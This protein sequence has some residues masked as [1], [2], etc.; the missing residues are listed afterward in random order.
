MFLNQVSKIY[1]NIFI[2][3]CSLMAIFCFSEIVNSASKININTADT[4]MLDSLP[5]IGVA[6]AEDIIDYR[7]SNGSF[8]RIEDL[9][10]VTGIGQVTFDGLKD[11]ICVVDSEC[12][13][14]D[15]EDDNSDDIPPPTTYSDKIL[16]NE[17][18]PNPAGSDT[19][20]WV[21][22]FNNSDLDVDLSG[23]KISDADDHIFIIPDGTKILANNFFVVKN[24]SGVSLNN[25]GDLIKILQPDDNI[26]HS[27]TYGAGAED[28]YCWA[29][30][31]SGDFEW[32]TTCT[33][34]EINIITA[35][36]PPDTGGGGGGGSSSSSGDNSGYV[37][38]LVDKNAN[39]NTASG[40]KD[41][42][43]ITEIFPNPIGIDNNEWIEI[44]NT[45]TD[46]FY[47]DNWKLKDNQSEYIIKNTNLKAKNF[48]VFL[49]SDTKFVLN[50]GGDFVE[51]IDLDNK[52]VARA[53]YKTTAPENQSYNLCYKKWVWLDA[54][55]SAENLCPLPNKLPTAF[56]E[57]TTEEFSVGA[58]IVL[59]AYE[60]FDEDGQ[61][62]KYTWQFS[63]DI[64]EIDN[65]K[66]D[67]IFEIQNPFFKFKFLS[68]GK[69]KIT[70]IITDDLGGEDKFSFDINV[71]G[72]EVKKI[73]D[74]AN[75]TNKSNKASPTN[76]NYFI[77]TDLGNLREMEK[78]SKVLIQ[79]FVSAPPGILGE[80]IFYI[81]GS[82]VQIYFSKKDFPELALGDKIQISGTISSYYNET[83]VKIANK[84]DI[85][86][87]SQNNEEP[88]PHKILLDEIGEEYEG[89]LIEIS[90]D[91]TEIKPPYFWIDDGSAEARA[92]V[93]KTAPIDLDKINL[94]IGDHITLTGIVSETT[95]GYRILPR[96]E[97]DFLIG[98]TLGTSTEK[99]NKKVVWPYYVFPAI[100][101]I[102]LVIGGILWKNRR[103]KKVSEE[104]IVKF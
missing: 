103:E 8:L 41:K 12:E 80:D 24:M 14:V 23:W 54:S 27:A 55:Y 88:I 90:G 93:K 35:P 96:Y 81:A 66:Q 18:L 40:F 9:M 49:K 89:S 92:Y 95:S 82:G 50:N 65:Q 43:F 11:L 48:L 34:N 79:G 67:K 104:E 57:P 5:G 37:G 59:D 7:T 94:K 60:S 6:K 39:T 32:T 10:N 75:T 64:E 29:R 99:N 97:S 102:A 56:F 26:L 85:K 61:I 47:L 73:D 15:N 31:E 13:V 84:N 87:L 51:L 68:G 3:A 77:T 91:I 63:K 46:D 30:N 78:N 100:L 2:I 70:L 33:E 101:A 74:N 19:N 20:E 44:Y 25:D 62:M 28:N 58:E 53:E 4:A 42:I 17:L 22:L 36:E 52:S 45:T 1:K 72:E 16:V 21:E 76:T 38:Y 86:I 83:R 98:K 71:E 69:Q